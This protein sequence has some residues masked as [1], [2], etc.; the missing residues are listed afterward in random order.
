[1]NS[2][3]AL[4]QYAILD[5]LYYIFALQSATCWFKQIDIYIS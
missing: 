5:Y 2:S 4:L 3:K 1:M